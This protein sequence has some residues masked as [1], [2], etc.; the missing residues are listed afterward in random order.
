MSKLKSLLFWLREK[1]RQLQQLTILT[2][3][4]LKPYVY[5]FLKKF[6]KEAMGKLAQ[7]L[8][9]IESV[10]YLLDLFNGLIT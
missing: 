5:E 4:H 3:K 10:D 8:S 1:L 7:W 2:W 9:E 6:V